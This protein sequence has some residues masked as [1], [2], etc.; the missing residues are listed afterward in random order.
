MG[1]SF[2]Y[3]SKSP[4]TLFLYQYNEMSHSCTYDLQETSYSPILVIIVTIASP[5]HIHAAHFKGLEGRA[6]KKY[7]SWTIL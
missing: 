1:V 5:R 6:I 2:Y 3:I 4:C 7:K